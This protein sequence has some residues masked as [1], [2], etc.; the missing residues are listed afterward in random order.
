MKSATK[1]LIWVPIILVLAI[2]GLNVF[3]L[4][5]D[6]NA[7][8]GR[9]ESLLSDTLGRSIELRGE[10]GFEAS[11]IPSISLQDVVIG[12]PPWASRPNFATADEITLQMAL[13]PLFD[14]RIE[15]AR[16]GLRRADILFEQGPHDSNNWSF[17]HRSSTR[18]G[19]YTFAGLAELD[20][21]S[22]EL[23]YRSMQGDGR[24]VRIDTTH[25]SWPPGAQLKVNANGEFEGRQV[26]LSATAGTLT[27][28]LAKQPGKFPLDATAQVDNVQISAT[29]NLPV[30]L[31][32]DFSTT[33][34]LS[35]DDM[36]AVGRL[37]GRNLPA[38]GPFDVSATLDRTGDHFHISGLQA[39][40]PGWG[41]ARSLRFEGG[42]AE[43]SAEQPIEISI[44]G[45]YGE[46]RFSFKLKG[47]AL[48]KLRSDTG[49]W[50]VSIDASS[51]QSGL[52]AQGAVR[53]PMREARGRFDVDLHLA[54]GSSLP[55]SVSTR[56]KGYLPANLKGTLHASLETVSLRGIDLKAG[57]TTA[58]GT[59]SWERGQGAPRLD[60]DLKAGTIDLSPRLASSQAR[61]P[62]QAGAGALD[63][64]LNTAW[65]RGW[66]SKVSFTLSTLKG[67]AMPLHN[68]VLQGELHENRLDVATLQG[69]IPG[70][71][72]S[73]TGS[74]DVTEDTPSVSA[75][76]RS[77]AFDLGAL[78]EALGN[79]KVVSGELREP[80]MTLKGSGSSVR[81]LLTGSRIDARTTTS[82][83]SIGKG[84]S[85]RAIELKAHRFRATSRPAQPVT[86]MLD[87]ILNDVNVRTTGSVG[88]MSNWLNPDAPRKLALL[89]RGKGSKLDLTGNLILPWTGRMDLGYQL[90]GGQ[91]SRLGPLIHR[92]LPDL[93]N[94]SIKGAM[95]MDGDTLVLTDLAAAADGLEAE[96][97]VTVSGLQTRPAIS[98]SITIANL[99]LASPAGRSTRASPPGG[100]GIRRIP[101]VDLPI[102]DLRTINL[103]LQ[104]Y[105]NDLRWREDTIG[106]LRLKARLTDGHL[107]ID[108]VAGDLT[109]GGKLMGRVEYRASLRTPTASIDLSTDDF[110]YGRWL[111]NGDMSASARGLVDFHLDLKG[112]GSTTRELLATASGIQ[113]VVAGP[114]RFL[115]GDRL[116]LT[117]NIRNL[118]NFMLPRYLKNIEDS[119]EKSGIVCFASRWD[120]SNGVARSDDIVLDGV[121]TAI[122]AS[123][124]I[125]LASEEIDLL[126]YPRDK[127]IGLID[128]AFPVKVTGTIARPDYE[129]AKIPN[130]SALGFLDLSLAN[131]AHLVE[132]L[133]GLPTRFAASKNPADGFETNRCTEAIAR[134]D[135]KNPTAKG[136]RGL[137][138]RVRGLLQ[139]IKGNGTRPQPDSTYP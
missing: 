121:H 20:L 47:A 76:A 40:T 100:E 135:E 98:G 52:R 114:V 46:D 113:T 13:M 104:L 27:T 44:D 37:I 45:L 26:S 117:V 84:T 28:L 103:D 129:V 95:A 58:T 9:L 56:L 115:R 41:K 81:A 109:G 6:L 99:D 54:E 131:P 94:Y 34:S 35:G 136:S 91:L 70:G 132:T 122:A 17:G 83:L 138:A 133:E 22:V 128:V 92:P 139:R 14:R 55:Q 8:R 85:P 57:A 63:A 33:V 69:T 72:I 59:I 11:L 108:P 7:H 48:E 82:W 36:S 74:L 130:V 3:L 88:S 86:V 66:N 90:T 107:L 134:N 21:E 39:N 61:S 79:G 29:G 16:I 23:G 53:L 127:G 119:R 75:A 15:I 5:V 73:L 77:T 102:E 32:G 78:L 106:S 89:T 18:H 38:Q 2:A 112:R 50:P 124:A 49:E 96:A 25:A 1:I 120:V 65:L 4:T 19:L 116:R 43:L 111:N 51:G 12:N 64:P 110:N 97:N 105:L 101:D 10:I 87:G 137:G 123:G 24:R 68:L 62:R 30:P 80:E 71:R 67:L 42:Q 118:F 93:R 125:N 31:N 60:A 126:V